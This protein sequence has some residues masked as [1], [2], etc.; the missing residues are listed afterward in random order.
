MPGLG[1][2]TLQYSSA[3]YNPADRS[4]DPPAQ[5][6]SFDEKWTDDGSCVEWISLKENLVPAVAE[7]KLNKYVD[8]LKA[9]L[10]SGHPL[11]IPG[12]GT[13]QTNSQ[14]RIAFR[15]EGLP[16]RPDTLHLRQVNFGDPA[17]PTWTPPAST[18]PTYT[19]P[20]VPPA[21]SQEPV[22]Q[23]PVYQAPAY[24][25]PAHQEPVYQA[26]SYTEATPTPPP[27]VENTVAAEQP[28]AYPPAPW[29]LEEQQSKF[30]WWWVAIP[31]A[32]ALLATA[33]WWFVSNQS[34]MATGHNGDSEATA[35]PLDTMIV[36]PQDVTP[37]DSSA[38][39]AAYAPTDTIQYL[40]VF[41][42]FTNDRSGAEGRA[43]QLKRCCGVAVSMNYIGK[44]SSTVR[45]SVPYR[46]A[47]SD[48]A[49]IIKNIRVNYGK[50]F[51]AYLEM[52]NRN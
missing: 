34:T 35:V 42:E 17:A 8:A 38:A 12:I 40:V 43:R 10:E 41:A 49:D 4:L 46:S 14:G 15:E 37:P 18:T 3:R 52:M 26:P 2:F 6:V 16:S 50:G 36:T 51:H 48:T 33:I 21:V 20:Q 13:L 31:I 9:E 1:T 19:P 11:E 30:R 45:L 28:S 24:Q 39:P 47:V 29:E 32:A 23:E 5:Q 7:L 27:A 25:A 44:D 22:Y